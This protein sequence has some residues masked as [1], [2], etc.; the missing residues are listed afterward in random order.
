[1]KYGL[2]HG[3]EATVEELGAALRGQDLEGNAVREP[4]NIKV[5]VFDARGRFAREDGKLLKQ[6]VRGINSF[7]LT[8]QA[9]KTVSVL[10]SQ[11]GNEQRAELERYMM[12]SAKVALDHVLLTRRHISR[13]IDGAVVTEK[14]IG[15]VASL[16]LHV[17]ARQAA[18]EQA[19][20]PHL[21][22]HCTVVAAER[23]DGELVAFGN[24]QELYKWG[25]MLQ[26]GAVG[27]AELADLMVEG[28]YEIEPDSGR[29]ERFFEVKHVSRPLTERMKAR[30]GEVKQREAEKILELGHDLTRAERR[31]LALETRAPKGEVSPDV[32]A[33][34][35]SALGE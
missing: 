11:A 8:F 9:P 30:H 10:W 18:H 4:A 20:S 33:G 1:K 29:H 28:G 3:Q 27:R 25:G 16:S 15:Y 6:E 2:T 31:L 7:D 35:W 21:H 22:V 5:P 34:V 12:D 32:T 19:P 24:S 13:R 23:S 26:A 14:P 17:T